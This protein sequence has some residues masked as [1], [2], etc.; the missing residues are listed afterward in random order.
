MLVLLFFVAL[1][2]ILNY[3]IGYSRIESIHHQSFQVYSDGQQ[4]CFE[5]SIRD[6]V[7]RPTIDRH[8]LATMDETGWPFVSFLKLKKRQ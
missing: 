8:N 2:R 3:R 6:C 4:H 1:F 7:A 5:E